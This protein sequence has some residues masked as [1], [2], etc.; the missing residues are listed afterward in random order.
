M[1]LCYVALGKW[2]PHATVSLNGKQN[3]CEPPKRVQR[4]QICNV[5][6]IEAGTKLIVFPPST[7]A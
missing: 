4:S 5:T 3:L 2:L 1:E 7:H 6:K